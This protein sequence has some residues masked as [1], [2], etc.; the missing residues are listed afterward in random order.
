MLSA[1]LQGYFAPTKE[2]WQSWFA[3]HPE[4]LESSAMMLAS[5][6]ADIPEMHVQMPKFPVPTGETAESLLVKRFCRIGRTF[7]AN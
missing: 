1:H 4:W 6:T 3:D 2:E 5:C 7:K